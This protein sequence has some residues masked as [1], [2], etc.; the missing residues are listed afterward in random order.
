MVTVRISRQSMEIG[1]LAPVTAGITRIDAEVAGIAQGASTDDVRVSRVCVE[2]LGRRPPVASVTRVDAEVA[3][4]AQGASTG[5]A[6]VSRMSA[7][8]GARVVKRASVTRIDAEVA[9]L[10]QGASSGRALVSRISI[11]MGARRGSAGPVTPLPLADGIDVF[12]HNWVDEA[13]LL[14]RYETSVSTAPATGSESRRGLLLKPERTLSLLWQIHAD[15]DESTARLDR[16]V[17]M[18]RKLTDERIAVPLYMDQRELDAA[19]LSTDDTVFFDTSKGRFFTGARVVIVQLGISG[20]YKSH[21]FH[22]I[23]SMQDDRLTFDADLGVAVPAGSLVI[24]MIDCEVTLEAKAKY[25][26]AKNA[27]VTL[28]LEEIPG[29]SQLPPVK[30]DTPSGGQTFDDVPIFDY[31]PDWVQ[32]IERG[33]L[34]DGQKYRQGRANRVTKN[35]ARS[36]EWHK[37]NLT[38]L[39][40]AC[41]D[42]AR[43]DVWRVVEFFDT[44]RGRLRSYWHIDQDQT[45]TIESIDASGA[46]V[47]VGEIGDFD[48]FESE[49][50]GGWV[51]LVMRDGTV[52]VREAV[53]VQQVL[54]VFRITVDPPLPAGLQ[55][56]DVVRVATAR[57]SRFMKDELEEVWK[58]S[59]HMGT[60]VEIIETLEEKNVEL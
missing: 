5:R 34:R 47:G 45:W 4:L 49:L 46:F 35:A 27:A 52:Y 2:V 56:S 16:L 30:S 48:D 54:T 31:N 17:F 44:R 19:Y 53:T 58:H 12:L 38:G 57:R 60:T 33:R 18:L 59:G 14:T 24:P 51:G 8:V 6:L 39:R 3:G 28:E 29:A 11:E 15:D 25:V 32:G 7:E 42:T 26:T 36:R 20:S 9:G 21:S 22:I 23:E 1:A 41:A 43:D 37:L 50:E 55:V 10:A 13:R 40:G